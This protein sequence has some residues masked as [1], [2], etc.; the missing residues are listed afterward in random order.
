MTV[1]IW[2]LFSVLSGATIACDHQSIFGKRFT[3]SALGTHVPSL[4]SSCTSK[5]IRVAEN[6]ESY[7]VSN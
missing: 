6:K 5:H 4:D 1:S 3:V 2:S 7:Q